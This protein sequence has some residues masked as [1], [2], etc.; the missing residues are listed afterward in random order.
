MKH[1]AA[2][3]PGIRWRVFFEW[4]S[5]TIFGYKMIA[6]SSL[7]IA[8]I[9]Y[10]VWGHHMFVAGMSQEADMIFSFLTFIV[11]IP[12]GIKV[13]NWV[14]PLYKGD[15]RLKTPMLYELSF[16]LLFTIGGLTGLFL[17]VLAIDAHLHDTYFVVAHFHYVLIG[18]SVFPLLGALHYWFP[19]ITGRMP[20]D[21]AGIAAFGLIF[22]GFNLTFFPQHV[23]G[24]MG[25]PRRVYT[26][27][28]GFGWGSANLTSSIGSYIFAVGVAVSIANYFWSWRKRV[29]AGK[30]IEC[31]LDVPVE[32]CERRDP[33]GLYR[34]AR[35]GE[36]AEFTGVSAP[37][38]RPE[39]PELA[40]DTD[41]L[42]LDQ[43]VD[44]GGR[45]IIKKKIFDVAAEAAAGR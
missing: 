16:L 39:A 24:L 38:E 31:F 13:F 3:E 35:A 9:G 32:V 14:A 4:F 21:R 12:S 27:P 6:M 23:L 1:N 7:A 26:Y 15:I 37:Y 10:L 11:A 5:E 18:G 43:C 34:K 29:P 19:K 41:Q 22:L 45:R 2:V 8:F 42:S 30:F 17:G 36:I 20:G 33:K 28:E 44:L 40:L 25:M